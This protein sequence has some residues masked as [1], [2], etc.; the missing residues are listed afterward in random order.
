MKLLYFS[1]DIGNL[2]DDLNPWLWPRVL[3]DE[4]FDDSQSTCFLGIGSILNPASKLF[5]EAEAYPRKV[6]FGSGVRSDKETLTFDDSWQVFYLRG[7]K[8]R[9]MVVSPASAYITD[10]AYFLLLTQEYE[11]LR[12]TPKQHKIG[13]VPYF[14][15]MDKLN[16]ESIC[17]TL[18][19]KLISPLAGNLEQ[20]LEDIASCDYIIAEAMH[21]AILAD[22]LRVPWKRTTYFAQIH[23]SERVSEFKWQDWLQSIDVQCQPIALSYAQQKQRP[24][25]KNAIKNLRDRYRFNRAYKQTMGALRAH[26]RVSFSLSSEEKISQIKHECEQMKQRFL[27]SLQHS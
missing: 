26:D 1:A 5:K 21:G 16:W 15:S 2:G 25:I 10:A 24:G 19:W 23:E 27:H 6:I 7:P 20:Q 3:G 22:I 18:G 4:L 17:D 8:S 13:Y 12:E 14:R 11:K 9:E